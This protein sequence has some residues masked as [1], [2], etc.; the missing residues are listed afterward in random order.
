MNRRSRQAKY[1]AEHRHWRDRLLVAYAD[2]PDDVREAGRLWYPSAERVVSA[3]AEDF[4]QPI[5]QVAGIVAAL[6]PQTK[7]RQNIESARSVLS[8]QGRIMGYGANRNK[9]KRIAEGQPAL[10]VLGGDKV[11]AFWANLYGS[12]TAVTIDVWAQRAATGRDLP[13]AKGGKYRRLVRAY[14]AAA[15]IVGEVP[16]DFQAIV[17]LATRPMAEH[18]R[19]QAYLLGLETA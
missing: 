14:T 6:S 5:P 1:A 4:A 16:R 9:A 15:E 18:G 19:D 7:W 12:R 13:L 2:A 11:T 3:L 8:G 17:W 10:A